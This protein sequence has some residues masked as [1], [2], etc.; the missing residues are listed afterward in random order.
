MVP[1]EDSHQKIFHNYIMTLS[2][3]VFD[4]ARKKAR[5]EG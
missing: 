1:E 3:V 5:L 2:D 4:E